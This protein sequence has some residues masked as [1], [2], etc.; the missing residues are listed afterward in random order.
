[1]LQSTAVDD[2]QFEHDPHWFREPTRR[3]RLIAAALFIG[4]GLFFA[5]M[6]LVLAGWW[7]R[8]VVLGLGITSIFNGLRH[9]T[10]GTRSQQTT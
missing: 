7:F 4:F 3:E 2:P 6:F 1:M 9:A 10:S 8:W 5:A